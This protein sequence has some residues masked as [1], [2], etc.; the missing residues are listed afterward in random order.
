MLK[1]RTIESIKK[2]DS[3]IEEGNSLEKIYRYKKDLD[4]LSGVNKRINHEPFGSVISNEPFK[5]HMPNY[6]QMDSIYHIDCYLLLKLKEVN[7][8]YS[9]LMDSFD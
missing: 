6:K 4:E 7:H 2:K 8:Q 3:R 9:E 5:L 1:D